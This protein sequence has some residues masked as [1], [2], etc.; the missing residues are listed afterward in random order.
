MI[1][2]VYTPRSMHLAALAGD[3]E[4]MERLRAA[5]ADMASTFGDD[6]LDNY[7]SAPA[8]FTPAF[9][10]TIPLSS[11]ALL[12]PQLRGSWKAAGIQTGL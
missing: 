10:L 6:N 5:M 12:N 3:N 9:H 4:L 1:N 7:E 8:G 11:S 2:M